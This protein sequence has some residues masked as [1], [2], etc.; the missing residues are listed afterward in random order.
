MKKLFTL[1]EELN[2]IF[3]LINNKVMRCILF[4]MLITVFQAYAE[5]SYSQDARLSMEL[6]N[7]TVQD[8]L[9]EIEGQSEFFFLFN[10]K[11]VDVNR[12][13]D[14]SIE[15][16]DINEILTQVFQDSDVDFIV[17]D[18]QIVLSTA[19]Y[20]SSAKT[21]L[22]QGRTVSGLV[23]GQDGEPLIGVSISVKGTTVGTVTDLEGN[24]SLSDVPDDATLIFSYIGM[25]TQEIAVGNQTSINIT[26]EEDVLGLDEV[27]VVGYGTQR[28]I[29][30][31]GSIA[32]VSEEEISIVPVVR[33]D[34]ALQGRAAGVLMRQNSF[35]PGPG[36]ISLIIRGLNSI[37]GT[38]APLFVVDGMIGGD[39]NSL[40]PLDI[41]SI[42][43]LK[44]ASAA[45][46]Y[47]SRA[48]NG[49][50]LVTTKRGFVG[51]AKV[52]FDAYYGISQ[53][54]NPYEVMNPQQY[55]EYV[56]DVR[57]QDGIPLSYPDI[58]GVINQVGSGTDWQDELFGTGSQQKYYLN[59]S[60]GS[61]SVTYN[62]SVGYL[63]TTG[64][65]P[66]VDYSKL[67]TR[68]NVD[69]QATDFLKFFTGMNYARSVRNNMASTWD[70][71][72]GSI[73]V[74]ATPPMLSPTD[75]F[76]EYPPILYNTYETGT[77]SFYYNTFAALDAEI[78]EDLGSAMQ[79][80]F[81]AEVEFTDWLKY[82]IS[83][84]IQPTVNE[85][86]YFRPSYIPE[87]QYFTL[88]PVAS[89]G[90]TRVYDWLVE[91]MITF[92]KSFNDSHNL[93]VLAGTSTQKDR[94]E[95]TY[96]ATA[97]FVFDQYEFHN[98]GA[99]QQANNSVNS[100]LIEQQLQSF[101]GRINYNYKGRYLVQLNGR[102][103]GSSK[104]SPDN[105]WAFFPSGSIGWRISEEAFMDGSV[106]NNM[107]LR[108]SYGSIGSHGI[109]PY[110]TKAL[111]NGTFS[112][113]FNDVRVGTYKPAGIANK[114]LKWE[115]TTQLDIGL[116]M[117]VLQ[118]RLNV[119]LDYYHKKT[120]DLLLN[121][122]I[123]LV[124]NPTTSHNPSITKNIGALQN[125]GFE[126]SAGY[127][128]KAGADFTWSLDFNGTFQQN[129]ILDLALA[130]GQE[131]LL[132]G[133][134]LR[135]NY[136][137]L[138]EGQPFG[139]YVGYETNGLYQNQ[140]EID[141]S[142]QPA[143]KPG[144]MKYVDQNNDLVINHDDFKVLGNAYP[145]FF[146][147]ITANLHYKSFNLSIFFFS[148]LGHELFNF[149]LAQWKY[150]L[151]STQ[152]NK[153]ADVATER[154]TGPGTS[155]DIPR[156]GYK[157]VNITDGADGAIDR[158]VEDASFLKLRNV[159]LSYDLPTAFVN[160][161]KMTN[162]NV[163]IQGNN[164]L[165][166]TKY[167][168]MDPEANQMGGSVITLPLNSGYY[169]PTRSFMIGIQLGF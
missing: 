19:E 7:A 113:G 100:S 70:G 64:L 84:G 71:R 58:P 135:R 116:D 127:R 99:G 44:D 161:I 109:S 81:G 50:V 3:S 125:T 54:T 145:D 166:L 30:L 110:A 159:T 49:V 90:N 63:K 52:S 133:D 35:D 56:N 22:Q 5:N 10:R 102:Y 134:N 40:D 103:D 165:T 37:N 1:W 26:L 121:Q 13:V 98:L 144:D 130:E 41:E 2:C 87:P 128:S 9:D 25:V 32:S 38:N 132:L 107:K 83:L 91:N 45:S 42:D 156:A 158:M 164:L 157:P 34:Q 94:Y 14:V 16:Q 12:K 76:G 89:K 39:I 67:T 124:N 93:T 61:E 11:L 162:A 8:V 60:G 66:N 80:N 62:A 79:L 92:E 88:E 86:R 85:S 118:N 95:S 140:G 46:I 27:V 122:L 24:Y 106:F 169:P 120:T 97:N 142:A 73:N 48:A 68:F 65:M 115:T 43:V 136:Q 78:R 4:L 15:G 141:G 77:P 74:I 167:T 111:I 114:D 147:G 6:S 28:K 123:T 154:W 160:K 149:E 59:V 126:F 69:F 137:I 117:G 53:N 151:S 119:T 33:L 31:T 150:D 20:L 101:L 108:A 51:K 82:R 23:S 57:T 21:A 112:Y 36:S 131:S 168:G 139:D 17:L 104:F 153:F 148:M 47:G 72:S 96:A 146:G 143:S 105:R 129:K 75:E 163:Y 152:F 55:M 155:D 18:R 29:D 138:Q